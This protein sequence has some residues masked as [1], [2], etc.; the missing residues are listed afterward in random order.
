MSLSDVLRYC[1][2]ICVSLRMYDISMECPDGGT[3]NG[4]YD[5]IILDKRERSR[6][7]RSYYDVTRED[8]KMPLGE[9]RL[10][11]S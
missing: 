11:I 4:T 6:A 5:D 8:V 10:I 3:H 9:N 7:V 2:G 1:F